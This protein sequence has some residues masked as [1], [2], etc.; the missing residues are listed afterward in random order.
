[1]QLSP[2]VTQV[3]SQLAAAAALGNDSTRA[4]AAALAAATETAVRLALLSAVSAA[5]DEITAA[6]LDSPGAPAVAVRIDG[7]DLR[8]EVHLTE[9][10][11]PPAVAVGLDDADNTARISLRLPELL[12]GQIEAAARVNAVSVNSWILRAASTA[13]SGAEPRGRGRSAKGGQSSYHITGWVNG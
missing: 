6:L 13:L 10:A 2:Y 1:M 7:D 12:K 11:E 8:V 4:T 5:A 9:R 3:Q